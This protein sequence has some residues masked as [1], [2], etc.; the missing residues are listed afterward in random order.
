MLKMTILNESRGIIRADE[1]K[2]TFDQD[3]LRDSLLNCVAKKYDVDKFGQD[4]N[5][6]SFQSESIDKSKAMAFRELIRRLRK[7]F[8]TR[9]TIMVMIRFLSEWWL[10]LYLKNRQILR[11]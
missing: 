6:L 11:R 4:E 2:V 9:Q 10:I 5:W 8:Y 3:I 7:R 1:G